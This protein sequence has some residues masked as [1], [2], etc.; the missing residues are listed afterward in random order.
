M[1][2]LLR[3]LKFLLFD[4]A[5]T[6]FFLSLYSLTHN[7]M[8][9]VIAGLA[10]AL[11]QIGWELV[12]GKPVDALQ[13]VSLV[14]V[15]ASGLGAL[16]TGNPLYVMLQPSILYLLTGAAMLKRGWMN[17]YLP[18]RA[19]EY[20]PDLG[21]AF[22][23]VWAGLM[24]FSAAVNLMLALSL[25]LKSWG[26]AISAWGI[27]SKAALLLIQFGVMKSTGR[28]RYRARTATA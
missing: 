5:A 9:A 26:V 13:W 20:V 7:L 25:D 3:A 24:F 2:D 19:R 10:L 6:L 14:V 22:G 4:L 23:Y 16:D 28:R 27:A 17:R 12:R 18:P 1:K 8:L 11:G 15:A 21:L